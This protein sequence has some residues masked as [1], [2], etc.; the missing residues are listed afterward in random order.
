[1]NIGFSNGQRE[2]TLIRVW[3]SFF[4]NGI[5]TCGREYKNWSQNYD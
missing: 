4:V 2:T 5:A 3:R 1:M